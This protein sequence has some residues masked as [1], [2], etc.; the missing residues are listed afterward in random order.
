[1]KKLLPLLLVMGVTA[2]AWTIPVQK[3]TPAPAHPALSADSTPIAKKYH[4]QLFVRPDGAF[5]YDVFSGNK[6]FIHQETIPGIPGN[7]GFTSEKDA[8]KVAALVVNKLQQNIFPPTI[9]TEELKQL[10]VL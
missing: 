7:K 3:Q 1:M 2:C 5:G 9:T 8:T 6:K 10:H 4:Y